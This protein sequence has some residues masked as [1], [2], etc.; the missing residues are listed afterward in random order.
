MTDNANV[1]VGVVVAAIV[2][3]IIGVALY[4][5]FAVY[6]NK[7]ESIKE[8][9]KRLNKYRNEELEDIKAAAEVAELEAIESKKELQELEYTLKR[10]QAAVQAARNYPTR[11]GERRNDKLAKAIEALAKTQ[12]KTK[13][14]KQKV[15]TNE[16]FA[17]KQEERRERAMA[18]AMCKKFNCGYGYGDQ[19]PRNQAEQMQMGCAVTS[20]LWGD[21]Y[22]CDESRIP[23]LPTT[24]PLIK[25]TPSAIPNKLIPNIKNKTPPVNPNYTTTQPSEE[26]TAGTQ[27]IV[28]PNNP[29]TTPLPPLVSINHPSNTPPIVVINTIPS[30]T[31]PTF[32]PSQAGNDKPITAITPEPTDAPTDT[33]MEGEGAELAASDSFY[34]GPIPSNAEGF[35][36]SNSIY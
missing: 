23:T 17:A 36:S 32:R 12:K 6:N 34:G 5:W 9:Q 29:T 7:N 30:M 22:E 8:H 13:V 20:E 3:V 11:R 31:K 27:P 4:L 2:V 1:V 16:Q 15:L 19:L 21:D 28:I 33:P 26:P 18:A 24:T 10:E 25:T 14:I 35:L